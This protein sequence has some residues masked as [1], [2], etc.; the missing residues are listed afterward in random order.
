MKWSLSKSEFILILIIIF[1]IVYEIISGGF[2]SIDKNYNKTEID[3]TI[4]NYKVIDSIK[5]NIQ[6]KDTIIYNITIEY[7]TKYI[8]AKNLNDSA[9]VELFKALCTNDSLYGG[10]NIF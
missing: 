6:I 2:K 4:Y 10:E 5:Y 9:S 3:T 8:E 7:E 1:I